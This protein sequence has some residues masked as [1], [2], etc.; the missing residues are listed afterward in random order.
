MNT[1]DRCHALSA[2]LDV[3]LSRIEEGDQQSLQYARAAYFTILRNRPPFAFHNPDHLAL[4]IKLDRL[5]TRIR[6][7]VP[8][9]ARLV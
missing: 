5:R 6:R 9:D 4:D 1:A 8:D 2:A 7:L 3:A